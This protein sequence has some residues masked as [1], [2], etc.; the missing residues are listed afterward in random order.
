MANFIVAGQFTQ[1]NQCG[2]GPGLA[3][4]EG[5]LYC[6]HAGARDPS[7]WWCVFDPTTNTWSQDRQFTNGNEVGGDAALAIVNGVLYCAHSGNNDGYLWFCT[8]DSRSQTWSEDAR[9][10]RDNRGS[11]GVGLLVNPFA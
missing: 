8:F 2:S 3:V 9:L 4:H 6:V 10:G 1:G 11:F 5:R 7:L